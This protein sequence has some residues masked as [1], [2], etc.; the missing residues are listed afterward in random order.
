MQLLMYIGND[1]IEA[2]NLE[3]TM[4]PRP[5]YVGQFK[6]TLKVKYRDLIRQDPKNTPEFLVGD[7]KPAVNVHKS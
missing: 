4:I 3:P 1:L 5:G 6:R 7:P 2:V